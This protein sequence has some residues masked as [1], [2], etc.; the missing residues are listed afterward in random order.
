M[1]SNIYLIDTHCC[2]EHEVH[3][4]DKGVLEFKDEADES[5]GERGKAIDHHM[6]HLHAL[7]GENNGGPRRET[8]S[9]R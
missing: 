2:V 8:L 4:G 6:R 7:A 3:E 1:L 9:S 5:S